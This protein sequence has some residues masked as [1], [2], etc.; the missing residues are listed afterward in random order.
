MTRVAFILFYS[1]LELGVGQ[2]VA[3]LKKEGHDTA[4]FY[5]KRRRATLKRNVRNFDPQEFHVM[6]TRSSRDMILS[7]A[8]PISE[9]EKQLL[10]SELAKFKPDLIGLSLR[11]IALRRAVEITDLLRKQ[12]SVP[13]VWGGIEPTIEPEKCIQHAD[14]VCVGEGEEPFLELVRR[15]DAGNQYTDIPGLWVRHDGEIIRNPMGAPIEDLDSLPFSD[16]SPENKFLI[17]ADHVTAGYSVRHFGGMYEI[18]TSRGCPFSCSFCCNDFLKQLHPGYRRIRRRSPEHVVGELV[19]AR[20]THDIT[21]VNVQDDVFTFDTAWIDEFARLYARDVGI[22]FC[23]YSHPA[24]ADREVLATLKRAGLNCVTIGIQS[25]SER[26]LKDVYYR[27]V[28]NERALQAMETLDQLGIRYN[29]DIITNNPFETEEDCRQTLDLLFNAPRRCQLNG[30]LSK[31]SFFPSTRIER[32][33]LE[34]A[35]PPQLDN[36]MFDFYNK[37][38]LLAD[39][40]VR[41]KLVRR[42]SDSRFLRAHPGALAPLFAVPWI[43]ESVIFLAK[44][45]LPPNVYEQLRYKLRSVR[46]RV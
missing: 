31:L 7:Y 24:M 5:L 9:K 38:Y 41:K 3:C 20:K 21:Y 36:R 23:A 29:V 35:S 25:G 4:V 39:S 19:E 33:L 8:E 18:I 11:T 28:S 22:P 10:C 30:G 32:M 15:I 17:D 45:A 26:I 46:G 44:N 13:I 34:S 2:L 6:V 43:K 16:Y 14:I 40:R 37:L 27:F 12:F 1:R 42:L